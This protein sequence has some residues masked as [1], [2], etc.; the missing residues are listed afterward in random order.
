MFFSLHLSQSSFPRPLPLKDEQECFELM[1]GGD[2]AARDRLISHNLRL[3][4][5]I[6]KKYYTTAN[7]QD[8]LISIGTIGLIKAVD[9]F[10]YSK[11]VRFATYASRCIE[12]EILMQFRAI[13]KTQN[14]MY[15]NDPLDTDSDGN[16]LTILDVISDDTDIGEEY[17]HRYNLSQIRLAVDSALCGREK[18]VVEMRFGLRSG[19]PMTQQQVASRLG[20]S[21]SYVSRIEKKAV[22]IL[23]KRFLE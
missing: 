5:H 17:E 20:I 23:K 1:A 22:E 13:R 19:Q 12:N 3:V 10:N 4:A 11:G 6:I 14:T 15:I 16:S 21:R 8:D 7:D 18:E 9:S 2:R